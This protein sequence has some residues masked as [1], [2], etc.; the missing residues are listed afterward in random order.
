MAR[1]QSIKVNNEAPRADYA[2]SDAT[3]DF[4]LELVEADNY[5]EI[6][7][8]FLEMEE[9][10]RRKKVKPI[11][12]GVKGGDKVRFLHEKLDNGGK[13]RLAI[14]EDPTNQKAVYQII[15]WSPTKEGQTSFRGYTYTDNRKK[16]T[17]EYEAKIGKN[18][19]KDILTEELLRKDFSKRDED[20]ID[21]ILR[22]ITRHEISP[23]EENV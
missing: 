15:R 12:L 17:T 8:P 18:C 21:V 6:P 23:G 14:K 16:G 5:S 7:A 10:F 20:E 11:S 13:I 22:Q 4:R 1:K 3:A 19:G 9:L 2:D